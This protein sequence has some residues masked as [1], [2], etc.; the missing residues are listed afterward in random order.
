[1]S[2][3]IL[4]KIIHEP[5]SHHP[6]FLEAGLTAPLLGLA[7]STLDL[8]PL[9]IAPW[10]SPA[11][12]MQS[13]GHLNRAGKKGG[14][15][16]DCQTSSTGHSCLR[17]FLELSLISGNTAVVR[18]TRR[19]WD[20]KPLTPDVPCSWQVEHKMPFQKPVATCGRALSSLF[21]RDGHQMP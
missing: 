16:P 2:C 10:A 20:L 14:K 21:T 9:C 12:W 1:M 4:H 15:S 7:G 11:Q 8:A 6:L 19:I 5:T 3:L 13:A 17:R 18:K